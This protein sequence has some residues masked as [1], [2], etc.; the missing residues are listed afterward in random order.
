[1][2]A[3]RVRKGGGSAVECDELLTVRPLQI[4][5]TTFCNIRDP[6]LR[7][8][9]FLRDLHL[10]VTGIAQVRNHLSPV[11]FIPF[12]RNCA[13]STSA[14][15]IDATITI[16]F[17][18]TLR[19]RMKLARTEAN[20]SQGALAKMLGIGQSTIASIEN[21]RNQSSGHLVQIALALGVN[22][23][24][25]AD[26]KGKMRDPAHAIPAPE[27]DEDGRLSI[28]RF[29]TGGAMGNG[30]ELRDQPGIIESLKVSHEWLQKNIK[31]YTAAA[32]LCI[33][34]GF[35]DSMQPMFN[36]GDPLIVDRG[37]SSVEFDAV[38][39]FRVGGE[40]FIKRLQ[41]IPTDN[42]MIL[43]AKSENKEYDSWDITPG[44]NFEVF[45]RILKVW[46]S[47]DF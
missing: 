44:M 22:P 42:G 47:R 6:R 8:A 32:N 38:Y 14:I 23:V 31:H 12:N 19:D 26:G 27:R 13:Y 24:W 36:P 35:G 1:M 17:M 10:R 41:R 18:K 21:G 4:G 3:P 7:F 11:H 46:C 30:L 25:L 15:A 37:V 5:V 34:T 29:E 2:G 9:E 45:G 16:A 20:V 28:P 40:G 33:V 43:R 39:F